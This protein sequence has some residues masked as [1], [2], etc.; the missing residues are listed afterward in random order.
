MLNATTEKYDSF[1]FK[2]KTLQPVEPVEHSL[3]IQLYC[4]NS[5]TETVT[6]LYFQIK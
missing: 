2:I 5:R 3:G 1:I 6:L 4:F